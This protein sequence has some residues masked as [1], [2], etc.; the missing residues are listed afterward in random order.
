M[1]TV[2]G[3][4]GNILGRTNSLLQ[5]ADVLRRKLLAVLLRKKPSVVNF[6][7]SA[8]AKIEVNKIDHC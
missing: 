3:T 4:L 1:L 8:L 5:R 2:T 6:L 7:V